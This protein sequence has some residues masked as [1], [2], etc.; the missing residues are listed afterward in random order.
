MAWSEN[1]ESVLWQ[2]DQF[3]FRFLLPNCNDSCRNIS[4]MTDWQFVGSPADHVQSILSVQGVPGG[5]QTTA[6]D[7]IVFRDNQFGLEL[8]YN[9][10]RPTGFDFKVKNIRTEK[11]PQVN[12]SFQWCFSAN[13]SLL[14]ESLDLTAKTVLRSSEATLLNLDP[15]G[16]IIETKRL[17]SGELEADLDFFQN[18][19]QATVSANG[20]S[21][22]ID[23]K[24]RDCWAI[25]AICKQKNTKLILAAFP[26]DVTHLSLKKSSDGSLTLAHKL[27]FGF[28]EKGVIR[29]ARFFVALL[30]GQASCDNA[31]ESLLKDCYLPKL[32]LEL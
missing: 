9:Q 4:G 31:A 5:I 21:N 27:N 30:D 1:K 15:T 12:S 19:D 24:S 22:L 7:P 17:E 23:R 26:G 18:L 10:D 14:D 28:L 8:H 13:T 16:S 20:Q 6:E 32:P 11:S 2:D 3:G 25:S 29:R